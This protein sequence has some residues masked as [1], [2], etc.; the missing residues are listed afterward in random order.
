MVSESAGESD[1]IHKQG[2]GLEEEFGEFVSRD[3]DC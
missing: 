1:A 3:S 2:K